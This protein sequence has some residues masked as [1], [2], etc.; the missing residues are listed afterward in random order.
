MARQALATVL[1]GSKKYKV[2]AEVLLENL[3]V[4]TKESG[5]LLCERAEETLEML[6]GA[7]AAA[8]DEEQLEAL[9]KRFSL[10]RAQIEAA[11]ASLAV[12]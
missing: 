5:E 4:L 11:L 12:E 2:A 8:E 1:F 10:T 6:I 3:N 9:Q 7:C